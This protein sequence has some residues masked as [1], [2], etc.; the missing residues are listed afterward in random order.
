MTDDPTAK[1]FQKN[2][3][4]DSL[5]NRNRKGTHGIYHPLGARKAFE[6]DKENLIT[7]GQ[8][9]LND[10]SSAERREERELD[11]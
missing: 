3:T 5:R 4:T 2:N 8:R 1:P 9:G 11:E 7:L 6:H 10:F